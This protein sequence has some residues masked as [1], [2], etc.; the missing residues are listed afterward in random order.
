MDE[1]KYNIIIGL[2][3]GSEGKGKISGYLVDRYNPHLIV[4][5]FSPNAGHTI[6]MGNKK[7][8]RFLKKLPK[9]GIFGT[10]PEHKHI[11]DMIR[12][13]PRSRGE[14]YLNFL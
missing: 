1:G 12:Y 3:A 9:I 10:G 13:K 7:I 2:Q 8:K 5:N 4:G 11:I 6:V 14:L